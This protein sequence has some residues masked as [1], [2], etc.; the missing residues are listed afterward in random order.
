MKPERSV[1]ET[2]KQSGSPTDF[3]CST[4]CPD[5]GDPGPFLL[6]GLFRHKGIFKVEADEF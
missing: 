6:D 3:T 2:E 1:L 5:F 4:P